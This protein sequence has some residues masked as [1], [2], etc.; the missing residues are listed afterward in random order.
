MASKK[1]Y[2]SVS[3]AYLEK[4]NNDVL[5]HINSL[6]INISNFD[7]FISFSMIFVKKYTE[8]NNNG[9]PFHF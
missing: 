9:L 7:V 6:N 8:N 1:C 2:E 3:Y 4:V 5:E